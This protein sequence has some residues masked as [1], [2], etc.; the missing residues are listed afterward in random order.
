MISAKFQA[1]WHIINKDRK[2][3]WSFNR[4]LGHTHCNSF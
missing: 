4:S 1:G 3:Q 2:E